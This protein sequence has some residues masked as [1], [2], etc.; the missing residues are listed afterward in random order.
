MR[1]QFLVFLVRL[2]V[3]AIGLALSVRLFSDDGVTTGNFWTYV[4]AALIFSLV[5]AVMK[6]LMVILSLPFIIISMGLFMLV[7]NGLLVYIA[8]LLAPGI[9]MSFG[10][11]I[12]TGIIMS[13]LNYIVTSVFDPTRET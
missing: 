12:L 6:P 10:A 9:D 8:L 13:L 7:V 5:N 4:L 2:L 3:N 1:Q 11:A